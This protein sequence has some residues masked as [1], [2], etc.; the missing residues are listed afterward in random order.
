[1][2][3][4]LQPSSSRAASR[5]PRTRMSTTRASG[6]PSA[7][8]DSLTTLS[9]V[10]IKNKSSIHITETEKLDGPAVSALGVRSR[11]LSNV[12]KGYRM[13]DQ[14]VLS[15]TPPSLGRHVKPPVSRR[16]DVV[17]VKIIAESLSQH[18]EN[19]LYRPHLVR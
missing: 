12:L 11:K 4:V 13:G 16:V 9:M 6:S 15:R 14:N 8:S 17:F 10:R 18:D 5:T 2:N 19:L 7:A 1:M 3:V